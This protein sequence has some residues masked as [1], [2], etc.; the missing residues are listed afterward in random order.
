MSTVLP[1][2]KGLLYLT[3][4]VCPPFY[5]L[6]TILFL[7]VNKQSP[8]CSS[9]STLLLLGTERNTGG[10]APM[11]VILLTRGYQSPGDQLKG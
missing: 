5:R 6:K 8:H 4:S 2:A 1:D 9:S 7:P 11:C 10:M 3:L